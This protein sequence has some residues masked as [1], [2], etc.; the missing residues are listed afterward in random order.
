MNLVLN[1][2]MA[3]AAGTAYALSS[4]ESISIV[5]E[6]FAGLDVIKKDTYSKLHD[7]CARAGSF[8]AAT[9]MLDEAEELFIKNNFKPEQ[10]D[11]ERTKKDGKV[12]K[13]KFLPDDY[14]SAKSVLLGALRQGI[15][16]FG[17]DGEAL[18][19]SALSKAQSEGK[20]TAA[21]KIQ[22]QLES[23]L[24]IIRKE[25]PEVQ[26]ELIAAV[27]ATVDGWIPATSTV[28]IAE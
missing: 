28:A 8:E 24:K 26:V 14:Q 6:E 4:A 12:K 3:S 9:A 5:I 27:C 25:S 18:G 11:A 13:S 15:P 17:E 21:E 7:S 1:S 23:I 20:K 16:L 19:K 22:A 10:I 2:V